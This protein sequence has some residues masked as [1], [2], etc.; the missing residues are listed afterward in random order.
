MIIFHTK[1]FRRMNIKGSPKERLFSEVPDFA[2]FQHKTEPERK[3]NLI[4]TCSN[5]KSKI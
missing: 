1:I 3:T 5:Q 4:G 2:F